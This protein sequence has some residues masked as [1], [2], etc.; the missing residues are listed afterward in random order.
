MSA[1]EKIQAAPIA[2][3]LLL[4][5]GLFGL[6]YFNSTTEVQTIESLIQAEQAAIAKEE[7]KVA[8]AEKITSEKGR[9]EQEMDQVSQL[10]RA[11]VEY[12]PTKL[13]SQEILARITSEARSAGVNLSSIQPKNSQ[14]KGFYEELMVDVEVEGNYTQLVTFLFYTTRLKR[15][16]N[17][18]GLELRVKAKSED[19]PI[20]AM[21][22]TLVAYR[23]L[24]GK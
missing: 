23:Y 8:E 15:I 6:N 4:G 24:E 2:L 11:A 1:V 21:K 3:F 7:G 20:L 16:V 17:I 9:Y 22:G 18:R 10:L 12:L 13:N 19:G 5:G 14:D